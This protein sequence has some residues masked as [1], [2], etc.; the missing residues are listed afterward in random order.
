MDYHRKREFPRPAELPGESLALFLPSA[1]VPIHVNAHLPYRSKTPGSVT[2]SMLEP[3]ENLSVILFHF[4]GMEPYAHPDIFRITGGQRRHRIKRGHVDTREYHAR[5]TG[6][7][8]AEHRIRSLAVEVGHVYV[9][10]GIGHYRLLP[11]SFSTRRRNGSRSESDSDV[12][13]S[14]EIALAE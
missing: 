4:R 10:V 13:L 9:G 2:E 14:A 5:D 6:I 12:A 1:L 7:H 8:G 11:V 3:V